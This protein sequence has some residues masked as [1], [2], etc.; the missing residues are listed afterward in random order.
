MPD[1]ISPVILRAGHRAQAI[2]TLHAIADSFSKVPFALL[3]ERVDM[4]RHDVT[5]SQ[6]IAFADEHGA[7]IALGNRGARWVTATLADENLHG[8]E[9][10][11][12]LF[13]DQQFANEAEDT[14]FRTHNSECV[15]D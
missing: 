1:T 2:A 9:V 5:L 14:A 11:M 7:K 12:T 3:P 13:L 15:T 8:I 6:F 10:Q 4:V